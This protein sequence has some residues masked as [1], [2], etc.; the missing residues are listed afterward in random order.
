MHLTPD[1]LGSDGIDV[2]VTSVEKRDMNL[3]K[4]I[5]WRKRLEDDDSVPAEGAAHLPSN[6][7]VGPFGVRLPQQHVQ[8]A[9]DAESSDLPRTFK[10]LLEAEEL[11]EFFDRPHFGRGRSLGANCRSY[12][13]LGLGERELVAEFQNIMHLM[14]QRR[15]AKRNRLEREIG[16][17]E[18]VSEV[19][20]AELRLACQHLDQEI[21]ILE[22]QAVLAGEHQGWVLKP[23]NSFR[24]GVNRGVREAL[25]FL[26]LCA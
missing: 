17:L 4:L 18:G 11:R 8:G 15:R 13:A 23:L 7:V 22:Q 16:N 19:I 6:V 3:N 1:L 25:E 24:A 21:A 12:D 20:I 10:G 2:N 26:M 9:Q 14:T 5:F